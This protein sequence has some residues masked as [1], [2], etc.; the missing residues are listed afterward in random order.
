VELDLRGREPAVLPI[1]ATGFPPYDELVL[2]V[3]E[4]A[5]DDDPGA[6]RSLVAALAEGTADVRRDPTPALRELLADRPPAEA[7]LQRAIVDATLPLFSPPEGQPYGWQEAPRWEALG[8]FLK[9]A[10]L[11]DRPVPVG[12]AFTNELLAGEGLE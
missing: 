11:I 6:L 10:G 12:Q 4:D 1:E 3:R 5:L 2:T 8:R 7:E 9:E